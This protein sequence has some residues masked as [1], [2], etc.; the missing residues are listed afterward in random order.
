MKINFY[1]ILFVTLFFSHGLIFSQTCLS[2]GVDFSNQL[3]IDEF[4]LNYPNCIEILGNV[5]IN[6]NDIVN[7]DGLSTINVINGNLNIFNNNNLNNITGLASLTTIGGNLFFRGNN[8]ISSLAGLN[9]LNSIGGF[10]ELFENS[11]LNDI[12]ALSQITS[13]NKHIFISFNQSLQ[14]FNGLHNIV[15][16]GHRLEISRNSVL[17]L[18]GLE[19]L[20]TIGG[21]LYIIDNDELISLEGL[22]NLNSLNN[23]EVNFNDNIQS[24]NGIQNVG[25]FNII[26]M[27][28]NPNLTFCSTDNI[29]SHLESGGSAT[30]TNN[31][32][33]CSSITQINT[34][35]DTLSINTFKIN[36]IT[37]Y[38]TIVND[39]LTF[40]GID[41]LTEIRIFDVSGKVTKAFKTLENKIDLSSYKSGIYFIQFKT[42]NLISIK[43]VIKL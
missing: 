24:L 25:S 41:A 30:V 16:I 20:T 10:L 27:Q 11:S 9:S 5:E 22:E 37:I 15:S 26:E 18:E 28:Y 39:K 32:S 6:G 13:I 34:N 40:S 35:C 43:K 19:S 36:E 14:N 3:Q 8:L 31:S 12:S 38:P 17:N 1:L 33:G 29:C 23:L 7:L 2:G 21:T 42:Q 4:Q